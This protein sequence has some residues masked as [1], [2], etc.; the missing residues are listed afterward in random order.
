M[1]MKAVKRKV[2]KWRRQAKVSALDVIRAKRSKD[3]FEQGIFEAAQSKGVPFEEIN[4]KLAM[5]KGE[6]YYVL[7]DVVSDSWIVQWDS[8]Q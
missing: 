4:G 6:K 1:M 7:A 2:I 5:R 3:G 8:D